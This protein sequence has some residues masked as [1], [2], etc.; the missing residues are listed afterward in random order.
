MSLI[1]GAVFCIL[2]TMMLDK[3][4]FLLSGV[5]FGSSSFCFAV[6]LFDRYNLK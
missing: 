2:G 4:W 1:P 6:A 5:F 3:G